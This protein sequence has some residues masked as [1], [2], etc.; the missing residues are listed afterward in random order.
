VQLA[1]AG[2]ELGLGD[3]LEAQLVAGVGRVGDQ[4]AQEDL[5]VRV[6]RVGDQ[7]QNLGDL[8]FELAGFGDGR[9]HGRVQLRAKGKMVVAPWG[10]L[11]GPT[12]HHPRAGGTGL[13]ETRQLGRRFGR[14]AAVSRPHGR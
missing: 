14:Q 13:E 3:R 2:G 12:P 6:Q 8:G 9:V 1:V 7:V 10:M 4:L 11:G 5:L